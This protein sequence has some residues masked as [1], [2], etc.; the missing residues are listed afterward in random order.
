MLISENE[1]FRQEINAD[2]RHWSFSAHFS[3]VLGHTKPIRSFWKRKWKLPLRTVFS[4]NK[5]VREHKFAWNLYISALFFKT[6]KEKNISHLHPIFYEGLLSFHLHVCMLQVHVHCST[7]T[8]YG[9]RH[10][11]SSWFISYPAN[12][13]IGLLDAE[14]REYV[15][16][17]TQ[18]VTREEETISHIV[19]SKDKQ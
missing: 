19:L 4:E 11:D 1:R 16:K 5:P 13:R 6:T 2:Q 18:L 10:S 7:N 3:L 17:S 14:V 12:R 8:K 15:C 9:R